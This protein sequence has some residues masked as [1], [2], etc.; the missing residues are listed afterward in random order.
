MPNES[1]HHE[2]N[3]VKLLAAVGLAGEKYSVFILLIIWVHKKSKTIH[4]LKFYQQNNS[5]VN[6]KNLSEIS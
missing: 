4:F 5:I 1:S 6:Y 2:T 3:M